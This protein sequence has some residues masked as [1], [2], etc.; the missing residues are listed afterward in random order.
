MCGHGSVCPVERAVLVKLEGK[1]LPGVIA[2]RCGEGHVFLV[3]PPEKK[4]RK[5]HGE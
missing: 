5:K 1:E 3:A 4:A 2:Y